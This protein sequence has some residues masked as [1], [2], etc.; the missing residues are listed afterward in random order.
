M[1]GVA[2]W[3]NPEA[4]ARSDLR[5]AVDAE[6]CTGCESCLDRC[7]FGALSIVEEVC[8]VDPD[9]CLGCG[10]CVSVCPTEA[11]SLERRPQEERL[12]IPADEKDWMLRRARE[13]GIDI[14]GV[15]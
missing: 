2:E 3:G 8:R 9:R 7:R 15:L 5:T 13:R 11:L 1:R 10:Q 14:S 4:M 12:K 6:L